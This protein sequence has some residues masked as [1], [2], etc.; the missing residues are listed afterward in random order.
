MF[1]YRNKVLGRLW[2]QSPAS[3]FWGL[4]AQFMST[5]S[6]NQGD[7][8]TY[9]HARKCMYTCGHCVPEDTHHVQIQTVYTETC[10]VLQTT[11]R[12]S[13]LGGAVVEEVTGSPCSCSH[14]HSVAGAL[15][16]PGLALLLS[17]TAHCSGLQTKGFPKEGLNTSE[18]NTWVR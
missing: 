15:A 17:L 8:H 7:T 6:N 10:L 4:S 5:Q 2:N 9:A 14:C 18:A 1:Y 3:E 16:S 13:D 12:A 11:C